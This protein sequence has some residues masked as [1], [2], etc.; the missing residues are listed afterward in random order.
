M[1]WFFD[2]LG[3]FDFFRVSAVEGKGVGR[4]FGGLGPFAG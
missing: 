4:G 2:V 1:V 3:D